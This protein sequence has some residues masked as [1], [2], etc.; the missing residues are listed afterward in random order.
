M[1]VSICYA[2]EAYR[3]SQRI[4]EFTAKFIGK[5]DVTH[6][7]GPADIDSEF[8]KENTEILSIER[9]NGLW[10]WKPYFIDRTLQQLNE[11]DY[12]IYTD[13][14]TIYYRNAK[15]L[16]ALL[17]NSEQAAMLFELPL[18]E[19]EWTKPFV[20][21]ALGLNEHKYLFSNQRSGTIMIFKNTPNTKKLVSEWLSLCKQKAFLDFNKSNE[22]KG[23]FLIHH[24][25]D[26]SVLS[27][28][29]KK[30]GIK[31]FSDPTDYGKFPTQYIFF[32]SLFSQNEYSSPYKL[33]KTYFIHHRGYNIFLYYIKFILKSLFINFI[34]RPR[35]ISK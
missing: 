5:V 8:S 13:S 30:H 32:N 21:E 29:S 22:K 10:L 12:L 2:N 26:Q 17:E 15:K 1:I 4:N 18:V 11:K 33:N 19:A 7:F 25:E 9:G 23:D 24:R 28:L 16:I 35:S 20:F 3:K 31:A 27:L 6:N 34:Y 14:S